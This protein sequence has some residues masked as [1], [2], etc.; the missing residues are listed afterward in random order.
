MSLKD[1]HYEMSHCLRCSWC[2][3]VPFQLIKSKRFANICPSISLRNFHTWS[4]GGRV[5]LGLA[6]TEGRITEYTEGM[7]QAVFECSMCGGCQSSCRVNNFNLNNIEVLQEIRQHFVEQGQLIPEHMAAIDGLKK[8]DNVFGEPKADRGKWAEGLDFLKDANAEK[9]GILLHV[10]C[11]ISYD[12]DL[13][14]IVRIAASI[15]NKA[16]LDVAIAGRNEACCG[17]RAYEMGYLGEIEKYAEDVAG[18]VKACGATKLVALCGDGYATFKNFYPSL[19]LDLPCEV[20]HITEILEQVINEGKIKLSTKIPMKVT[21]HD[22][23]HLG[24]RGEPGVKWEGE[25]KRLASNLYGAVPE[26]PVKL[27]VKG[28]YDPPRNVLN[29]IPGLELVEMERKREYGWCCGAGGGA[30][31]AFDDFASYAASERLEEARSTGA[32]AMVTACGWCER[33]FKDAADESGDGMQIFDVLELVSM[34][35][36]NKEKSNEKK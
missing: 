29:A 1:Y 10:G 16:G 6:L 23:C 7:K 32:E 24:R 36:G 8:E 17:G 33:S 31:E 18:R 26:K 2:K 22:P 11:R 20:L 21:Y 9:A 14:P 28:C 27:G 30:W 35:M 5:G 12:E 13:W 15:M 34:A 19:G 25:Y 3:F 4:A